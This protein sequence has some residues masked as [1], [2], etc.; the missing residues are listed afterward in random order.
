MD[1]RLELQVKPFTQRIL[2]QDSILLIG[3]CFTDHISKRL[4]MHKFQVLENPHGILFNPR[5]I[6]TAVNAYI[7]NKKYQQEDLFLFNDLYTSWE[8]HGQFSHPDANTVLQMMNEAV[9]K[10]HSFL[11]TAKWVIITLGSSWVYELKNNSLGGK[12][13]Q[14]AANCH[15][16]PQQHFNHRLLSADDVNTSLQ[17]IVTAIQ[18]FNPSANIIFTISP[19][20]HHREGLV[21]NNRSKALLISAVHKMY[22]T[23]SKLFYFPSYELIIDDLRDYRFYAEDLVHPN[24]QAT[25]YVWEKFVAACIG[26]ATQKDMDEIA[27]IVH[28]KKHRSL[29]P[30]SKQHQQ[31]LATMLERTK[32]LQQRLVGLDFSEELGYFGAD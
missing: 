13:N 5:S 9:T 30:S 22:E 12:E 18:N 3:S 4:A 7:V 6:E 14:T 21:E 2:L 20:R 10:A 26:E 28:A 27:K 1:F 16:V 19:V 31:F 25:Q 17:S 8:H 32:L 29:H 15:K 24:Y 11:K 23:N